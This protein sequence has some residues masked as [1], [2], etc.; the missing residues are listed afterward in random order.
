MRAGYGQK[1]RKFFAEKTDPFIL[2]DFAGQKIFEEATVD[3]NIL[4]YRKSSNNG[5]TLACTVKADCSNNLSDYVKQNGSTS[6]YD[7]DESWTILSSIEQS[8]HQ[9]IQQ[10]GVPLKKW[11]IQINFG[12]KTGYNEAF[13]I[14]SEKRSELIAQDS[15]SAEIIRPILRGRDIKRY[16]YEN[17]DLWLIALFPSKHYDIENY[18]AVKNY[19]LSFGLKKLEQTG[20]E[21][22]RSCN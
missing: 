5:Q 16:S 20:K 18:P 3:V 14:S 12:I 15:K 21:Y 7:S 13:I 9:K 11:D 8:I 1:L 4:L 10:Y 6:S 22:I 2:I 17:K 19:L